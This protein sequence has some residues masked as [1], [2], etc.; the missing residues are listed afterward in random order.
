MD[1][2]ALINT[3]VESGSDFNPQSTSWQTN[4][5]A[6]Y[7]TDINTGEPSAWDYYDSPLKTNQFYNNVD[8]DYQNQL[9]YSDAVSYTHLTL[10]TKA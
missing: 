3:S 10:P 8:D 7:P 6:A 1:A 5:F 2:D 4:T 9:G